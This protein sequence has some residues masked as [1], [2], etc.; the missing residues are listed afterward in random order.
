MRANEGL[1]ETAR[2]IREFGG[3]REF[4]FHRFLHIQLPS[5]SELAAAQQPKFWR[6]F[7]PSTLIRNSAE[8]IAAMSLP[9]STPLAPS[10][11]ARIRSLLKALASGMISPIEFA[12]RVYKLGMQACHHAAA[13]DGSG[14]EEREEMFDLSRLER[15]TIARALAKCNGKR[16]E[17]AHLLGI[18]KTTLYRKIAAYDIQPNKLL[19][20]PGCG[21]Q[22]RQLS[23]SP[24]SD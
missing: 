24:S 10:D 14:P 13:N 12:E 7:T 16:L 19:T 23:V 22:L 8:E 21:C 17:T 11:E 4:L 5:G 3:P 9:I 15:A 1:E 2:D 18:G 6:A 20:C